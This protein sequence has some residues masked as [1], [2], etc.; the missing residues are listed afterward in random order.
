MDPR[1]SLS[2]RARAGTRRFLGEDLDRVVNQLP[3]VS[4]RAEFAYG[5]GARSLNGLIR[6]RGWPGTG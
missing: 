6:E 3:V 1:A 2:S 5:F 4:E